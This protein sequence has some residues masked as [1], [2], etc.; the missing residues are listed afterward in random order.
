MFVCRAYLLNGSINCKYLKLISNDKRDSD[1]DTCKGRR[2]VP[3]FAEST[4]THHPPEKN[5]K[6]RSLVPLKPLLS[7]VSSLHF[8]KHQAL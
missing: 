7:R 6:L 1:I 5:P 8:Q 3:I 4:N 2:Q